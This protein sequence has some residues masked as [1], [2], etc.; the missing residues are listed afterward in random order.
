M[1][2]LQY[3]SSREPSQLVLCQ[4]AGP[5]AHQTHQTTSEVSLIEDGQHFGDQRRVLFR[6]QR[7]GH[8][9]GQ[10]D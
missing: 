4:K 2:I 8:T 9:K 1:Q 6:E 7:R 5:Y 10:S 3:I